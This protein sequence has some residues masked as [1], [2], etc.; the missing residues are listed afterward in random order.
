MIQFKF[1]A[2]WH[3]LKHVVVGCTYA[4]SFYEPIKSSNIRESLQRIARETEEDYQSLISTLHAFGVHIDRP[5]LDQNL[6]IIDFIDSN[7]RI[8]YS[9]ANSHTLI[10]KPPMQ[11][12]DSILVVGD[13]LLITNQQGERFKEL[14]DRDSVITVKESDFFD[15]PYVNVVGD[16]LIIDCK[17]NPILASTIQNIFPSYKIRTADI[18]GHHDAVF[19]LPKP[20]LVIST[21]HHITYRDTLP[22]WRVE[23]IENLSWNAI[24]G[25]RKIKRCNQNRWWVPESIQNIEFAE[26]VDT[27]LSTWLG[28]VAETVFDVNMLQIDHSTI[29]VNNYNSYLF[30]LLKQHKIEPIIVPFR[31]RFFWDGGLHCITADMYR[32]GERESYVR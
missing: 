11:P 15:A 12:R 10:P 20:G 8:D 18:G 6:T 3:R 31:H 5:T 19:C 26:F 21:H 23:F 16:T 28:F 13:K 22:G 25:W 7:G 24:P 9:T 2:P 29:L 17:D 14:L 1:N 4:A 32:E 30:S 27:W